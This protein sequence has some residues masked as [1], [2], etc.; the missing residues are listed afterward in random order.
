MALTIHRYANP[1]YDQ[2]PAMAYTRVYAPCCDD[3]DLPD[4]SGSPQLASPGSPERFLLP[5][6]A[7]CESPELTGTTKLARSADLGSSAEFTTS[8]A[9][10][11][12]LFASRPHSYWFPVLTP[13]YVQ[14]TEPDSPRMALADPPMCESPDLKGTD[15]RTVGRGEPA[16]SSY[17]NIS[18]DSTDIID[19]LAPTTSAEELPLAAPRTA[20][21]TSKKHRGVNGF[22]KKLARQARRLCPSCCRPCVMA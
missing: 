7:I 12:V 19:T 5:E 10:A 22:F 21:P 2:G 6:P 13:S 18:A 14:Q 17:C 9:I 20:P 3:G 16:A 1:V 4:L 15:K 8:S 11:R